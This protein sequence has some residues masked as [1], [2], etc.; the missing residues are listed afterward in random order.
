MKKIFLLTACVF[1]VTVLFAQIDSLKVVKPSDSLEVTVVKKKKS[2]VDLAGRSN[3]HFLIQLGYAGWSGETTGINFKGLSR[4][5]NTYFMFDFPFKTSPKLSAA[6]GAGI[7]TDHIFF[8]KTYV[9]LTDQ[10][11]ELAIQDR[12][13]TNHFKKY[14]LATAWL[15]A[16]IELRFSA[17]PETPGKG[18]KAAIG[19]KVGTLLNA[20][21]KGKT[22]Q[23]SNGTTLNSYTE[24]L[25]SKKFF[26]TT[27]IVPTVRLGYGHFSL[28]G[29]YEVGS[30]FKSGVAPDI[31]PY[32]I[33]LTI[34]GL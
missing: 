8:S 7:G 32:S 33:G 34:S 18:F 22:M 24:K 25:S 14:K 5:F 30:L 2:V 4:S 23:N 10:T 3:D 11:S 12:S 9:G 29:A 28:Y 17:H 16:P 20:H 19:I 6:I 13:D 15:E 1:C 26:N 21:T 27:R 31:K